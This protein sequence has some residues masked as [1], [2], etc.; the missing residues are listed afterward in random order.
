MTDYLDP[1]PEAELIP[2]P[3]AFHCTPTG[4]IVDEN[5]HIEFAEWLKFGEMLEKV[6][7][8]IQWLIG[9][10]LNWGEHKYGETYAQAVNQSQADTWANYKW[11][12]NRIP[13][14]S[15]NE[16]L[17]WSHHRAVAH[18][19]AEEQQRLLYVAE[20][21]GYSYRQLRQL[22]DGHHP[23]APPFDG[24][25]WRRAWKAAAKSKHAEA[26]VWMTIKEHLDS[27]IV[28]IYKQVH[29]FLQRY[30]LNDAWSEFL[31]EE[32]TDE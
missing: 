9:D 17:S 31:A 19:P 18:L 27:T 13:F 11:V 4:L 2:A 22:V 12:S 23:D 10:W 26:Q 16:N 25:A 29:E 20:E 8:S 30:D 6:E 1:E 32:Q 7:Q 28:S 24:D 5:Q 14:S 15:R 21:Q 3:P